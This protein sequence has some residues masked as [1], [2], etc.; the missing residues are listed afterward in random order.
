MTMPNSTINPN[1]ADAINIPHEHFQYKTIAIY[2]D[3]SGAG[4]ALSTLRSNGFT[5]NQISLLGREQ[6]N[7]EENL[8]LEWAAQET[9]KGALT[10]AALGSIPGLVIVA[11]TVLTGGAGLL[12]F[13]P[14][15]ALTALGLGTIGGG[16]GG[17]II[18]A[19]NSIDSDEEPTDID[20]AVKDAIGLGHWVVIAHCYDHDEATRAQLLLQNGRIVPEI[21]VEADS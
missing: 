9:A 20:T 16:I 21:K 6:E 15:V 11:G 5:D 4:A 17:G 13:G 8:K 10:G 2:P 18:G 1:R 12:V 14:M 7:W 3:F 19:T